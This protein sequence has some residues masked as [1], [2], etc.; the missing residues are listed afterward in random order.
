MLPDKSFCQNSL[1]LFREAAKHNKNCCR[2]MKYFICFVSIPSTPSVPS[3]LWSILRPSVPSTPSACLR[4]SVPSIA[5]SE[6]YILENTPLGG[7]GI[8]ANVIWRKKYEKVKR[9][10]GKMQKKKKERREKRKK[11]ERKRKKG[12]RKRVQ[13][14]ALW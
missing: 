11:V 12:E 8:S 14:R 1:F 5:L 6:A 13:S 2:L 9:N 4:S 10:R 7:G 3:T